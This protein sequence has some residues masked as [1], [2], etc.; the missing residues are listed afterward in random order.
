MQFFFLILSVCLFI[1]LYCIYT[2]SNDDF[3]FLRRDVTLE[4]IFNI[5]FTGSLVSL[6]TAR[7]FYGFSY[8]KTDFLN[9][10][11]FALFPYFPGLSLVGAIVGAGAYLVFLKTR[12]KNLLPSERIADFISISF[13][14]ALPVGFIG[15]LLFSGGKEM[16][17]L[18]L[19]A[20]LYFVL[21]IIFLNFFLPRLLY[22]KIKEGTITLLFLIFF[23]LI[24]FVFSA[25][26][27]VNPTECLRNFE[28]V[29]L[30]LIFV[31][32]LGLLFKHEQIL[33]I[34]KFGKKKNDKN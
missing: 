25:L 15:I 8:G 21:F 33:K 13:L 28:N 1:F 6:F 19:Q 4:K 10:F 17:M 5:I 34:I 3:I 22:K 2:L 30:I 7:L 26:S 14:I 27:A 18:G 12:S 23:A 29:V 16:L 31:V 11:I 24:N 32:A 20:L 9:P